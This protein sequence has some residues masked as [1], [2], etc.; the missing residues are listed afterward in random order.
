MLADVV[1]SDVRGYSLS[2]FEEVPSCNGL[3]MVRSGC[4]VEQ[5]KPCSFA[6][7]AIFCPVESHFKIMDVFV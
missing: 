4:A 7:S 5:Q 2:T 6:H 3:T 1:F